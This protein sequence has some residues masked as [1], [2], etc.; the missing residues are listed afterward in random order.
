MRFSATATLGEPYSRHF[1]GKVRELR[2]PLHP[3]DVRVAYWLAP[4]RRVVVRPGKSGGCYVCERHAV[5]SLHRPRSQRL[6]IS[7][8]GYGYLA[9]GEPVEGGD[10]VGEDVDVGE[11]SCGG[12]VQGEELV[13]REF[14]RGERRPGRSRRGGEIRRRVQGQVDQ[15]GAVS[16]AD[17]HPAPMG[18]K[19]PTRGSQA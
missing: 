1:G 18:P 13:A 17:D 5:R 3:L 11:V 12:P 14:F 8:V 16:A 15:D 6:Q 4:G 19:F 2:I 7:L 9:V 10:H